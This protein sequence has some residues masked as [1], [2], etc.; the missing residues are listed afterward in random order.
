MPTNKPRLDRGSAAQGINPAARP[1]DTYSRPARPADPVRP[2]QTNPLTQLADA[3]KG[4]S[5][6]LR[7]YAESA[8]QEKLEDSEREAEERLAGLTYEEAKAL[9][10]KGELAL[11]DDPFYQ[12]AINKFYGRKLGAHVRQD[13]VRRFNGENTSGDPLKPNHFNRSKEDLEKWM[14]TETGTLL[15][16]LQGDDAR[17]AFLK[18]MGSTVNQLRNLELNKRAGDAQTASAQVAYEGFSELLAS[19]LEMGKDPSQIV[20]ELHGTYGDMTEAL[21]LDQRQLDK[22]ATQAAAVLAERGE[23]D[24]VKAILTTDRGQGGSIA[25]QK[26]LAGTSLKLLDAARK[27]WLENTREEQFNSLVYFGDQAAQGL[28]DEDQLAAYRSENPDVVSNAQARSWVE[29]SRASLRAAQKALAKDSAKAAKEQAYADQ[30]RNLDDILS[31]MA[32]DGT[33]HTLRPITIIKENGDEK[34]LDA[35]A[36]RVRAVENYLT[37]ESPRL[38]Q[39]NEETAEQT[40]Q[41]ELKWFSNNGEAH[42]V[43][44]ASLERGFA[45]VNLPS[46]TGEELPPALMDGVGTYMRLHAVAPTYLTTLVKDPAA[47]DFYESVRVSMQFL[48]LNQ[49]QAMLTALHLARDPEKFQ[50]RANGI[51]FE[52]LSS[53]VRDI[54]RN[55]VTLGLFGEPVSNV[56]IVANDLERL[57]KVYV[58]NGMGVEPALDL[59]KDKIMETHTMVNGALVPI[60]DR[61]LEPTAFANQLTTLGMEPRPFE[62]IVEDYLNNNALVRQGGTPMPWDTLPVD[63]V[64]VGSEWT[65]RPSGS[66]FGAWVIVDAKTLMPVFADP[67]RNPGWQPIVTFDQLLGFEQERQAKAREEALEETLKDQRDTESNTRWMQDWKEKNEERQRRFEENYQKSLDKIKGR[68]DALLGIPQD[69]DKS[70]VTAPEDGEDQKKVAQKYLARLKEARAAR[71]AE[72]AEYTAI[73]NPENPD[74]PRKGVAAAAYRDLLDEVNEVFGSAENFAKLIQ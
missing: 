36:L 4:I 56:G 58:A 30:M 18:E 35:D 64:Q 29:Q 34:V 3:L 59:A 38:A 32:G 74:G 27:K 22:V 25:D 39:M 23:H 15:E 43:M 17:E 70:A 65:I 52:Q 28:L 10:E 33:L 54:E 26:D 48:G 42:P 60:N 1:V 40:W 46:L 68:K 9:R 47:T 37:Q 57:A 14:A 20:S 19:G 66:A 16:S 44:E 6:V 72:G 7:Q 31:E 53:R 73:T 71:D 2:L 21:G 62:D 51:K 55:D 12:Q 63:E 11:H 24:L 5:P 41:R 61:R 50:S 8:H 69:E 49:E 45:T 13:M 67:E